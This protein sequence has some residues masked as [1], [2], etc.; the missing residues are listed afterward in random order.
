LD[1]ANLPKAGL[2]E[3]N[4]RWA[5]LQGADLHRAG[6]HRAHLVGAGLTKAVLFEAR[7]I[8][9]N[10]LKANL[11]GADLL[12]ADLTGANL[13][14]ADLTLTNLA[15][16]IHGERCRGNGVDRGPARL[17]GRLCDHPFGALP[18]MTAPQSR[19][20]APDFPM[21]A[22]QSF[23]CG[24]HDAALGCEPIRWSQATGLCSRPQGV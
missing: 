5:N 24:A 23:A 4:L 6:L 10:L 8:G 22:T 17:G 12:G 18:V 16:R 3:A 14:Q 21:G 20:A 9:A 13:W 7:L 11:C 2:R 15:G 1:D 19:R